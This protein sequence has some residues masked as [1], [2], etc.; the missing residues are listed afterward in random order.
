MKTE[1]ERINDLCKITDVS[2]CRDK[3]GL[4]LEPSSLIQKP[5]LST[6]VYAITVFYCFKS[7]KYIS[8][9]EFGSHQ[10]IYISVVYINMHYMHI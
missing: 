9:S 8:E 7:K 2:W 5:V 6:E 4:S 10:H 3:A 1:S